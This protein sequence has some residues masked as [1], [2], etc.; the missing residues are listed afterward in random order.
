M[1]GIYCNNLVQ[2]IFIFVVMFEGYEDVVEETWVTTTGGNQRAMVTPTTTGPAVTSL[3]FLPSTTQA[4]STWVTKLTT[5]ITSTLAPAEAYQGV[6]KPSSST[7]AAVARQML[8]TWIEVNFYNFAWLV[9]I[10]YWLEL[11][12]F[13][14]DN[15]EKEKLETSV[16]RL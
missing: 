6:Q 9:S 10:F 2:I 8:Q 11:I 12:Y 1:L 4:P 15:D 7:E 5:V 13:K 14:S 3:P 16:L